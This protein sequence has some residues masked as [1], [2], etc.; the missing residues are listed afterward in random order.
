MTHS[1]ASSAKSSVEAALRAAGL[2]V[3]REDASAWSG[4]I[5]GW[6]YPWNASLVD[7]WFTFELR[8]NEPLPD[9]LELL[10]RSGSAL[11]GGAKFALSPEGNIA[12]AFET[13]LPSDGDPAP[14]LHSG[15]E[16]V[17]A[18]LRA[19]TLTT[20]GRSALDSPSAGRVRFVAFRGDTPPLSVEELR[21]LA[22]ESGWPVKVR[23]QGVVA[24]LAVA[25]GFHQAVVLAEGQGVRVFTD[26]VSLAGMAGESRRAIAVALLLLNDSVRSV[27]ASVY[28]GA[29]H[30]SARLSIALPPRPDAAL[31]GESLTALSA[32]C[33]WVHR[34]LAA[35]ADPELANAFLTTAGFPLSQQHQ[36]VTTNT[37]HHHETQYSHPQPV[38]S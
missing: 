2:T 24:D 26:L 31:L 13:R 30:E 15:V 32:G 33:R 37:K 21:Q 19:W 29:N 28:G 7:D 1:P 20:A 38:G 12:V 3:R 17:S 6:P 35:L 36:P 8:L 25:D 9:E 5:G 11:S 34:E 27:A 22:E 4:N 18:G 14:L 16:G 10:A 23:D